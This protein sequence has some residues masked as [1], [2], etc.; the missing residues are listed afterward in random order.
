MSSV[1]L[2]YMHS[3]LRS[4]EQVLSGEDADIFKQL[5]ERMQRHCLNDLLGDKSTTLVEAIIESIKQVTEIVCL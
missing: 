1:E 4:L 2:V 5:S 3:I